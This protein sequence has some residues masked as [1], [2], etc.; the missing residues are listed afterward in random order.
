MVGNLLG[1]QTGRPWSRPTARMGAS[2]AEPIYLIVVSIHCI[3]LVVTVGLRCHEQCLNK[4]GYIR[5][6]LREG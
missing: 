3:R 5:L 2:R 4:K 1:R 6:I